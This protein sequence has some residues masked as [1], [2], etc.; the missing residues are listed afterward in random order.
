M[1]RPEG[2]VPPELF[3]NELEAKKYSVSS[4]MIEIQTEIAQR[5]LDMLAL[6]EDKPAHILD[7]GCGSG[8]S[9]NVIEQ[10]GHCKYITNYMISL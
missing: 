6:P 7:I 4:R 3:Y 9:G 10:N 1:S 8:L 2:T 5:A